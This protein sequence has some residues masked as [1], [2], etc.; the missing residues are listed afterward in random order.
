MKQKRQ[1]SL[2]WEFLATI[3]DRLFLIVFIL[4]VLIVTLGNLLNYSNNYKSHNFRHDGNWKD[5][6]TP[7]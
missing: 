2:E 6:P 1:C 5:G 3:L 7:L 4:V